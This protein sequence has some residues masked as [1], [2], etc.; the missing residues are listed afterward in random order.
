MKVETY[1]N[2]DSNRYISSH[3]IDDSPKEK[4]QLDED[5]SKQ[6]CSKKDDKCT[7]QTMSRSYFKVH[8]KNVHD[9]LKYECGKC[10]YKATVRSNLNAHNESIHE[11]VRYKCD[12]CTYRTSWRTHLSAHLK[13]RH[14]EKLESIKNNHA[15][16]A[17]I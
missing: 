5:E 16:F 10:D 15:Y 11:G 17:T 4:D 9:G 6:N 3:V 2:E 8:K 12:T 1:S 7:F 13:S 14:S